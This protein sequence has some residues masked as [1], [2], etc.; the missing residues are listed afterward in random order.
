MKHLTSQTRYFIKLFIRICRKF[1][2]SHGKNP[3]HQRAMGIYCSMGNDKA[4][5]ASAHN[6]KDQ[7]IGKNIRVN[8]TRTSVKINYQSRMVERWSF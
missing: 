3:R 1:S 5:I 4:N 6:Q 7:N 8:S 2:G